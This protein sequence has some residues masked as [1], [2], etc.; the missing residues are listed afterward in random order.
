MEG[1]SWNIPFIWVI[2]GD[3]LLATISPGANLHPSPR[4]DSAPLVC[5]VWKC[6]GVS[7]LFHSDS[8]DFSG[9]VALV[10]HSWLGVQLAPGA[11][12]TLQVQLGLEALLGWCPAQRFSLHFA[13]KQLSFCYYL[14]CS[15]FPHI[16]Q[17]TGMKKHH[18][19][20]NLANKYTF[21]RVQ[22]RR[23]VVVNS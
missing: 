14:C 4:T 23:K 21:P 9:F 12:P 17:A 2:A 7:L 15:I 1:C 5:G 11:L 16:P 3:N 10:T 18:L 6:G 13:L 19:K 20:S 22:I 8:G